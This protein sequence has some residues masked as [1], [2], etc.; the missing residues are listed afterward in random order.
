MPT[1]LKKEKLVLLSTMTTKPGDTIVSSALP[2]AGVSFVHKDGAPALP[3]KFKGLEWP[4]GYNIGF[5]EDPGGRYQYITR[6][7]DRWIH[8][9]QAPHYAGLNSYLLFKTYLGPPGSSSEKKKTC[10]SACVQGKPCCDSSEDEAPQPKRTQKKTPHAVPAKKPK[11]T[12][13]EAAAAVPPEVEAAV[14][15]LLAQLS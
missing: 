14:Q 8:E 2:P 7:G 5:A 1:P 12:V 10:C 4:S 9:P 3:G 6:P 15:A 13:A 11:Q